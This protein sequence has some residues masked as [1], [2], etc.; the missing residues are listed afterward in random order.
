M[1]TFSR[2]FTAGAVITVATVSG[3]AWAQVPF[4]VVSPANGAS[5][6]ETVRMQIPRSGLGEAKYLTLTID[7]VFRA[8][9]DI[10]RYKTPNPIRTDIVEGGER[11]VNVLW[12]TKAISKDPKVPEDQR[13][14]SDGAHTLEIGAYDAGGKRIGVQTLT[15]NV[16]NK[17]Q[18][19]SPASGV[20]LS[21]AL[22]VGDRAQY[23]QKTEVEYIG[24]PQT[25]PAPGG[26]IPGGGGFPGG[27]F[28]GGGRPGGFGGPP[29]GFG[30]GPPQGFGGGGRGGPSGG[31][32]VPQQR[33]TG[34]V[35]LPVQNVTA[36]YERTVEDR[37]DKSR[38]FLLRDKVLNGII[39]GGNGGIDRL[40]NVFNFKSRYQTIG[41][42]GYL[43]EFAP[44]PASAPGAYVAL[45]V[46][47]IS[48]SRRR[49][50]DTWRVKAPVSLEWATLDKPPMVDTD[51]RLEALE[52]QN[53]YQTARIAQTYNGKADIPIY[54]GAGTMKGADVKMTRT[55]WFAYRSQ[56]VIRT[57]T[58]VNVSG[59]A[60]AAI[61]SAMVPQAGVSAG[62]GGFGGGGG[63]PGFGGGDDEGGA[64]PGFGG[65]G[66][67]P[68]GGGVGAGFGGV[69]GQAAEVLVPAKFRSNTVVSLNVP[70]PAGKKTV[71]VVKRKK[72]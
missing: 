29:Q 19:P 9:I 51:N 10:P 61:V 27:G 18:L 8:G 42:G 63:V 34:P 7:G 53:G 49:V 58:Q 36:N 32:F 39:V 1:R 5:V 26:Y 15:L 11:Y 69:Q 72:K 57:E 52:W 41:S 31:G 47:D 2:F 16:N 6:R 40:E 71:I 68:G 60:P 12:N 38:T 54:G 55:I 70:K 4:Q 65:G 48:D 43:E 28:P 66:G 35:V 33:P 13:S 25:A 62:M 23:R 14:V 59:N 67:I 22:R 24:D 50:G 21:Y 44:A 17:G 56:R 46:I 30:G 64:I 37:G 3:A 45:P 20:L